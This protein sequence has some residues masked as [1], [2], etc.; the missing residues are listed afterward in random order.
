LLNGLRGKVIA[1]L[2]PIIP[3]GNI[4]IRKQQANLHNEDQNGNGS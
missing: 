3:I 2:I 4:V 1:L